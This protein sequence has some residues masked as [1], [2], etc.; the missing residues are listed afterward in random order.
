VAVE[1]E[2]KAIYQAYR[3]ENKLTYTGIEYLYLL[4]KHNK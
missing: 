2:T 4:Y 1:L 3:Q